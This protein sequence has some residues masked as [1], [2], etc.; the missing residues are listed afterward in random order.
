MN[1]RHFL[2]T[3]S[4]AATIL[5]QCFLGITI[6][7][8]FVPLNPWIPGRGL[9]PSWVNAL[10]QA[11]AQ[12]LVFGRD[13]VFT[14][15]PYASIMTRAY[16][17][18]T[19]NMMVFGSL[20]LGVCYVLALMLLLY[21]RKSV[22]L[23]PLI[24]FYAANF[25]YARNVLLFSYPLLLLFLIYRIT[26]PDDILEKHGR[27]A[28]ETLLASFLFSPLG[29][30]PLIKGSLLLMT[31]VSMILSFCMLAF[32]RRRVLACC[33]VGSPL[34]AALIFWL[35]AGQ[36]VSGITHYF[37][38][39]IPIISGYT[40]AMSEPGRSGD[41]F[42]YLVAA[43]MIFYV[44]ISNRATPVLSCAFLGLSV[45][46]FLFI[47]FKG[48]FVRH[49][50]HALTAGMAILT[51]AVLLVL[52]LINHR[53]VYLMLV[54]ALL[55]WAY[56]DCGYLTPFDGILYNTFVHTYQ[57]A[58]AG[59]TSRIY[60]PN[61]FK[62]RFQNRIMEIKKASLIPL[63]PGTTDIYSYNQS[64]LLASGNIW[65]PRPV[66]QS[67]SAYTPRL[68]RLNEAHLTGSHAPDN[69]LFKVEPIDGRVPS[70][71]DGLSW[72]ILINDYRPEKLDGGFL[73]LAKN[74]NANVIP[75]KATIGTSFHHLGEKVLLPKTS[76]ILFAKISIEPTLLGRVLS[77]LYKPSRLKIRIELDNGTR[78]IYQFIPGIAKS[79]FI[80]S[81]LVENTKDFF[82][83]FGM[84]KYS[85]DRFVKSIIIL[86]HHERHIFWKTKYLITLIR[87]EKI[88]KYDVMKIMHKKL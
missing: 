73:Y 46:A 41:I 24:P 51:A 43:A 47:A 78:K 62:N 88:A 60:H 5:L 44:I 29:L 87:I 54:L 59:M 7:A 4:Y 64:L 6:L 28:R 61:Q 36:P 55:A 68:A 9:D 1:H 20:Y 53:K 57:D 27:S 52:V 86:S 67:Y 10:N 69:I 49:D 56:I 26:L 3:T 70:F 76:G 23:L 74:H 80:L 39:M 48:G 25:L 82:L 8:K 11:V 65:S 35:L 19:D 21:K 45:A 84:P 81:P 50:A 38:N 13:I 31:A 63:L 18:A 71:E 16:H 2:K 12:G 32:T 40:A 17:P 58:L 30:L 85:K 75:A 83:L 79:G 66:F 15:G 72:P 37:Y 77:I 42:V 14:Y 22:F 34:I 33:C